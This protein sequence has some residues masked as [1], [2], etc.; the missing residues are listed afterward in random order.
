M[1]IK[2]PTLVDS[3]GAEGHAAGIVFV[4]PQGQVLLLHRSAEEENYAG[5]WSWPGG[6][7]DDGE[8]PER[9][10]EREASEE[11]GGAAPIGRRRLL[12]QRRTPNGLVFHT[13]VQPVETCFAPILSPEHTGY[14]WAD[15][16]MLPKPLHPAVPRMLDEHNV[17]DGEELGEWAAIDDP[18][19]MA[20]D[21]IHAACKGRGCVGCGG[22][23]IAPVNNWPM[24]PGLGMDEALAA[25]AAEVN[26]Q[27][28][29]VLAFDR[30]PEGLELERRGIVVKLAFD[31]D[32]GQ[33][34]EVDGFERLHVKRAPI[35]KAGI[36]PYY[37]REIPKGNELGLDPAKV[38]RLLRHP[39]EIK[40]SASTFH[41]LPLLDRHVPHSADEHDGDITVGTV[42]SEA[43]Y[44]HPYL[45]NSLAI[46]NRQG[47][48]HVDSKSQKELSSA[49]SYDADMTPGTYEGEPYDGVMRNM[50]GNHVCLVKKGRAGSDVALDE[51]LQPQQEISMSKKA[52]KSMKATVAY[53]A[54]TA[55]L[56]PKLAMD[57]AMPN[58]AGALATFEPGKFKASTP[59]F[60]AALGKSLGK[61]KL[62]Q[63]GDLAGIVKGVE[64]LMASIDGDKTVEDA[65]VVDPEDTDLN[66]GGDLDDDTSMDGGMEAVAAYL[67][68][69]GVPDDVIAGMPG[70]EAPAEDED[71]AGKTPEEIEA[72]RLAKAGARDKDTVV[73]ENGPDGKEKPMTKGA[74]DAALKLVETNTIARMNAVSA[75]KAHVKPIVG[76]LDMAFDSAEGVYRQAFK[77]ENRDVSAIKGAGAEV[78]L[79][80]M[81]DLLPKPGAKKEPIAQDAAG[82]DDFSTRYPNAAKVR[83][84]G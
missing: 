58:L 20:Q 2:K 38:Y 46:W 12:D 19:D 84:A 59:A 11:T 80:S 56:K 47:R 31:R 65:A 55:F 37:G 42:G 10:A 24:K 5:H 83:K 18:D 16:D 67:K 60:V 33:G 50:V 35:T 4:G 71:T 27:R 73:G 34:Q 32:T 43:E 39:D 72:A 78:A 36:N 44:E 69:K 1:P 26:A 8:S 51:A 63:D 15:L 6:N 81:W 52:L 57:A 64:Q 79:R 70:M 66:Q 23:G 77:I 25:L 13:F 76:E 40:K 82:G 21:G 41:N 7:V 62:A 3:T 75:A 61:L 74:M 48:D 54:L 49:Y 45:Y 28:A 68:S 29:P 22:S 14:T 17:T 9:G 30:A 53:G